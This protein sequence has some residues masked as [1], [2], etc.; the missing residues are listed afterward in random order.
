MSKN[1]KLLMQA[2][3]G[4]AGTG[5][6]DNTFKNV[7][8]LIDGDAVNGDNNSTITDTAGNYTITDSSYVSKGAFSPFLPNW[9]VDLSGATNVL[10]GS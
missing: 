3:A 9:S 5:E 4:Q 2:A 1:S 10:E 7:T 8:L 6:G